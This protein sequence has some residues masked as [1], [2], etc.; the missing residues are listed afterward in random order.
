MRALRRAA[1]AAA[2]LVMLGAWP[3]GADAPSADVCLE[4]APDVI[5][6]DEWTALAG[7]VSDAIASHESLFPEPSLTSEGTRLD[8]SSGHPG[9]VAAAGPC[10]EAGHDWTARFGRAF[11]EAG[12][13]RLL[14]EAPTT[15]GIDSEVEIEWYPEETRLRT[16]LVFA[17]PLDIPNGTCWID[18]AMRVVDG[19]VVASGEQGVQTS[20]FAEGACGR[21]FEHLPQ[22]GAGEQ[23]VTLLPADVTLPDGSRLRFVAE[24]V[25]VRDEAV[26][27]AGRL[28]R[29]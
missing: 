6:V 5:A 25:F 23:A 1:A 29:D 10:L 3:V 17:G 14:E 13:D 16:T 18:D 21:F 11:L 26:L 12:A 20:P 28:D 4:V 22:G 8:I 9:L 24:A 27:V 19:T 7:P 2:C 15:P